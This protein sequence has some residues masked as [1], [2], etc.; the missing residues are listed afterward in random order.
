MRIL[1]HKAYEN[2]GCHD[3][4]DGKYHFAVWAPHAKAVSLVGDFNSWEQNQNPMKK[5]KNGIWDITI[6]SPK[7]GDVYKY[8]VTSE[9][10][11]TVLKSDPFAFHSETG[12]ATGSKVYK[13]LDFNWT[14][15]KWLERRA[16]SKPQSEAICIYELH[17]GSWRVP[18]EAEFPWYRE[19]AV[20]LSEYC[21]E[22]NYTHVEIMPVTEYPFEGSWGYQPTGYFAPTSRYGTPE[23]FQFF[24]NTLHEAGIGVIMDWVPAHF[25]KDEHGLVCF[26][27]TPLFEGWDKKMAEHAHWGTMCFDYGNPNVRDFLVS[28]A[29]FFFEY[30]HIDG[31]RV[32]AVSSMLYL[33]YGR[34]KGQ[35]TPNE[36]GGNISY[37]AAE[38]LRELNTAVLS[39]YP[40]AITSAEE[41]TAFPLVT[42]PPYDGG[43]GFTFKWDMGF[44]HDTLD[45]FSMDPLFRKGAHEKLSFSMMYAF[46]ENF[47]LPFS[48]DEVVHGKASM[49]N[50]M[51]GD[52]EQKFATLRSLFAYQYAH[53]GK[54]LN[55]MGSEFGQFIEWNNKQELDWML[56]DYPSHSSLKSFVSELNLFYIKHSQLF[57]IDDSWDGF[58][59]KSVDERE[60]SSIAFIRRNRAGKGVL[61][62]FNFTP[63]EMTIHLPMPPRSRPRTLF[64]SNELRFGGTGEKAKYSKGMLTI[65]PLTAVFLTA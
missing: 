62:A 17:L 7:Y 16:K 32:D 45:Y 22:M 53:P 55:F 38:F 46:S 52:Y 3:I 58:E 13:P 31:L 2:L 49:L 64:S 19:V 48:H 51:H 11:E 18:E 5:N 1:G 6:D 36:D 39:T 26:D 20:Q 24:V 28:S 61:C 50:K 14:D 23:D 43:L 4:G 34:E 40:G 29:M 35:Y 56:L 42:A 27:G 15:Q 8:A 12:P 57:E 37:K 30:Y 33:D 41:S 9:K 60:K 44:M 47:I 25:P 63:V 54:K 21:N 59:W 65:P 10:G